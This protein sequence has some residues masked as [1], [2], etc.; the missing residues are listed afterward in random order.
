MNFQMKYDDIDVCNQE[1][2]NYKNLLK[3]LEQKRE[4]QVCFI[5]IIFIIISLKLQ[6][7]VL[8]FLTPVF[9]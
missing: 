5:I 2:E 9:I 1:L 3:S 4:K 6:L 8:Y 7:C